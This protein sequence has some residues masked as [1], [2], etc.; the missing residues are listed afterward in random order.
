MIE[1]HSSGSTQST[2]DLDIFYS[3]LTKILPVENQ[4]SKKQKKNDDGPAGETLAE[5]SLK[6]QESQHL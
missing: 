5:N 3:Y 2:A 6:I 4:N 1:S